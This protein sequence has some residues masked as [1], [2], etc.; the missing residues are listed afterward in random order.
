MKDK[1]R[2][3][4]RRTFQEAVLATSDTSQCFQSGLK[5]FSRDHKSKI[6][7]AE[8]NK[9]GGSVELDE[10]VLKKYSSANRWDYIFDYKEEVFFVEFHSA[11][12]SEVSTMINKLKWLKDWLH[13]CAPEINKLKATSHSPFIW[14]QSNG[15]HILKNSPEQRR[16]AQARLETRFQIES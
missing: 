12:T 14:V 13:S 15:N 3:P 4:K 2:A 16:I 10:C 1:K 7:L 11:N 6:V 9:C 8:P 5:A